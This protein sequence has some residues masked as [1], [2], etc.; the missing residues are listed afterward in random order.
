MEKKIKYTIGLCVLLISATSAADKIPA[1]LLKSLNELNRAYPVVLEKGVLS[2][3]LKFD[4]IEALQARSV[5]Q[6]MCISYKS[7]DG[8]GRT[9]KAGAVDTVRII[10]ETISQGFIYQGGDKSCEGW[11]KADDED[12]YLNSR[13]SRVTF[14]LPQ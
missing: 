6:S 5:V 9:W 10:N 3:A 11:F 13:L 7:D 14:K 1:P 8:K 12:G 2:V 4:E